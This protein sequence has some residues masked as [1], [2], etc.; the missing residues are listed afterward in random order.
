V[1]Y[2]TQSTTTPESQGATAE[3]SP[4]DRQEIVKTM[5]MS[6]RLAFRTAQKTAHFDGCQ[7]TLREN[8]LHDYRG[9]IRPFASY[10]CA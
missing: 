1:R 2:G 6:V 10:R 9:T 8:D 5:T 3:I 4:D 7:I